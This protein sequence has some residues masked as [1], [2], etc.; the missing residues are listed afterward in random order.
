MEPTCSSIWTGHLQRRPSGDTQE[1]MK[2]LRSG[3]VKHDPQFSRKKRSSRAA[4]DAVAAL[5]TAGAGP[6]EA[7]ELVALS[8][9]EDVPSLNTVRKARNPGSRTVST[10]ME[11]LTLFKRTCDATVNPDSC[12][13]GY[14]QVL[15]ILLMISS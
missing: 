11:L 4:R 12:I 2:F 1:P 8:H 10:E 9:G 5:M 14:I 6:T 3:N 7:H 15:F 13:P